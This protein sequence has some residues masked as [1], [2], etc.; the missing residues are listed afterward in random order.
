M[1]ILVFLIQI[2]LVTAFQ[3]IVSIIESDL[4]VTYKYN[5]K[6]TFNIKKEVMV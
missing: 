1:L 6:I 2:K 4:T 3:L 5:L